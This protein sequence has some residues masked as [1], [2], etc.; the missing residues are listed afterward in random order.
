MILLSYI[1]CYSIYLKYK[2]VSKCMQSLIW[3]R[4]DGAENNAIKFAFWCRVRIIHMQG[5]FGQTWIILDQYFA[6]RHARECFAPIPALQGCHRYNSLSVLKAFLTLW[7]I[8]YFRCY[9]LTSF[10]ESRF[11]SWYYWVISSVIVYIWSINMYLSACKFSFESAVMAL[12]TMP[13]KF[14]YW[15]RVRIIHMAW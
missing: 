2:H 7:R 13:S 3:I 12:R 5:H 14:A 15:C 8:V 1:Q 11:W 10:R 4:C 9:R 6:S